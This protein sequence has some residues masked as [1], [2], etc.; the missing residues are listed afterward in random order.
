MNSAEVQVSVSV[1]G[2]SAPGLQVL[3]LGGEKEVWMRAESRAGDWELTQMKR[4]EPPV[5]KWKV[6]EQR[7]TLSKSV[8]FRQKLLQGVL[9]EW[10]PEEEE[11]VEAEAEAAVEEE[12]PRAREAAVEAPDEVP[13]EVAPGDSLAEEGVVVVPQLLRL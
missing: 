7:E 1:E 6:Q 13:V 4:R 9:V 8:R 11:V 5:V 12:T 10:I 2:R 3:N